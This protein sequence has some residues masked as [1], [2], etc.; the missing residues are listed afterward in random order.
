MMRGTR[1]QQ[2][3][4][5][6]LAKRKMGIAGGWGAAALRPA[7]LGVGGLDQPGSS[8]K[9]KRKEKNIRHNNKT[10]KIDYQRLEENRLV[11]VEGGA[12]K[13]GQTAHGPTVCQHFFFDHLSVISSITASPSDS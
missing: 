13:L 7:F 10:K 8:E 4:K 11:M 6:N 3:G 5:A 2:R 12:A 9:K 1:F